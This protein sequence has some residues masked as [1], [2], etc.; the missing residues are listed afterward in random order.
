M[1]PGRSFRLLFRPGRFLGEAGEG[2]ADGTFGG[3]VHGLRIVE[4]D[5]P[6][7]EEGG[8]A[9]DGGPD[10]RLCPWTRG[11]GQVAAVDE[12]VEFADENIMGVGFNRHC[13]FDA[14][15]PERETKDS[16]VL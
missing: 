13:G 11:P 3:A 8:H 14:A 9:V 10:G 7:G 6:V 5:D 12:A 4:L 1:R 16:R 2:R 15:G